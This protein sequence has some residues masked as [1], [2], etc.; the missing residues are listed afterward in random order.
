MAKNT[1]FTGGQAPQNEKLSYEQLEQLCSQLDQQARALQFRLEQSVS[2]FRR[3]DYLF[4]VL[5][6]KECF[7]FQYTQEVADEIKQ[8]MTIEEP[9]EEETK[10]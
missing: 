2:V 3:L 4:K 1:A 5:E 9:K 10:E 6:N 7:D 8:I